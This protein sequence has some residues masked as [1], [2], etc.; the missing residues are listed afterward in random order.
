MK[1]HE[2]IPG[3]VYQR[4]LPSGDRRASAL[5]GAGIGV[6]VNL[7]TVHDPDL[8][9]DPRFL[10]VANPIAD[11]SD[12]PM[13]AL[14]RMAQ[15]L[16]PTAR[17]GR[18]ILVHCRAG[19]NRSALFSALLVREL[20]GMTGAE[21]VEIVRAGRAGSLAN[22]EFV[23]QLEAMPAPR[24]RGRHLLYLIGEP[25]AGK[26]TLL[27]ALAEGLP[28]TPANGT[29]PYIVYGSTPLVAE[30]GARRDAFSGTDALAMSIQPKAVTWLHETP[31]E[32]VVAE[33][34]RL[35]NETFLRAAKAAGYDLTVAYV[36][37]KPETAIRRRE[38][39]ARELGR[40]PQNP[41]WVKG[42][43]TKCAKL[44]ALLPEHTV[45]VEH[46]DGSTER[47]V[48]GLVTRSPVAAVLR[49]PRLD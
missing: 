4:G 13:R 25:G 47:A 5:L 37:V 3:R 21:A 12:P 14:E 48:H 7:T 45:H 43:Q 28:S 8:A 24:T 35:A 18:A 1:L 38:A 36:R 31:H 9:S 42:R 32:Y 34:D 44:A 19:R 10:Y 15:A 16:A 23:R 40:D 46:E 39:R 27:A 30:L 41:T 2:I 11:G 22:D 20:Q 29:V 6:I 26:S 33:G 17:D 49:S